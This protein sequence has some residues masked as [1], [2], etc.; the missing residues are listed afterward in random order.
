MRNQ[1]HD[2]I[3]RMMRMIYGEDE[4]SGKQETTLPDTEPQPRQEFQEYDVFVEPE[5]E[6]IT[7]IKKKP[8]TVDAETSSPLKKEADPPLLSHKVSTQLASLTVIFSLF[9]LLATLLLQL[10]IFL[11]PPITTIYLFPK[12]KTITTSTVIQVPGRSLPAL[13]LS[14]SNTI[15][16]TGHGHQDAQRAHGFLTFYNGLFSSQSIAAGTQLTNTDGVTV[17]TDEPATI[18][19]A[20]PPYIGQ[21]TVAAHAM[22]TGPGGNIPAYT[23]DKTCCFTAVKAENTRGFS[24]GQNERDFSVVSQHDIDEAAAQVRNN[25]ATSEREALE[26]QLTSDE[27][28]TPPR[29]FEKITPDHQAGEEA[30]QVTIDVSETCSAVAYNA[31]Q[32][33]VDATK[34]LTKRAHTEL[35]AGYTLLGEAR[36]TILHVVTSDQTGAGATFTLK[37]TGTYI[38]HLTPGQEQ[39]LRTLIAGKSQRAALALLVHFPGIQTASMTLQGTSEMLPKDPS[40]IHIVI[41]V[42]E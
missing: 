20:N 40:S 4:A 10:H 11:N 6:R 30:A 25:L 39:H 42:E 2:E 7:F 31:R 37:A 41:I 19:P 32:L 1:T 15:A 35:G 26:A 12:V 23:I 8:V 9:L 16:A 14:Q 34:L 21:V 18:P 38:Y 17:I 3:D 28:L 36:I 29:C 22:Q 33:Y 13:T 24:G 5:E 27:Q